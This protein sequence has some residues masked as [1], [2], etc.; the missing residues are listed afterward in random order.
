MTGKNSVLYLDCSN[1]W[2]AGEVY[3][4]KLP[5]ISPNEA[6]RQ[7]KEHYSRQLMKKEYTITDIGLIYTG[8]FSDGADGKIRPIVSPF[9]EVE[10]YNGDTGVHVSFVYDAY[11]GE[12][13]WEGM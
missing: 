8:Y 9:W 11:R 13:V 12:C 10:I 6:L 4:E 3:K 5:V 7:V 1:M 2:D